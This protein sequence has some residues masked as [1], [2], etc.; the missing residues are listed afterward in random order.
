MPRSKGRTELRHLRSAALSDKWMKHRRGESSSCEAPLSPHGVPADNQGMD[1]P[2]EPVELEEAELE[3]LRRRAYGP[4]ADIAGDD[5]AQARLSELE[6]AQRRQ[7]TPV[8]DAAAPD[9]ALIARSAP[10][11]RAVEAPG[12]ASTSVPP[13]VDGASADPAP[14][15][16]SVT[17][18]DPA[19]ADSDPSNRPPP[20]A[21]WWRPRRWSAVL[22]VAIAALGLIA[23]G[24]WMSQLLADASTPAPTETA[25][26]EM[27][28][29]PAAPGRPDY[30]PRPDYVLALK[31]V[32]E[33]ADKP[34][35]PNGTLDALGISANELRRYEDFRGRYPPSIDVWSGESRFGMTCLLVAPSD[36]AN[37]YGF[38]AEGCS[39]KGTETILDVQMGSNGHERFVLSGDHV[40]VYLYDRAA[41]PNAS[42]G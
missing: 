15:R 24:A 35:D 27:P 5:A 31:S 2:R 12:S 26:P 16:G 25:S 10:V 37:T 17:W 19:D 22:G 36:Q 14:A 28:Q 33:D 42:Q 30:V 1:G 11:A 4:N 8:L 40:N 41:D 9:P 29:F 3:R 38:S 32:G 6:A 13:P 34:N 20:A 23:A 18:Q 7:S 39:L 21:P